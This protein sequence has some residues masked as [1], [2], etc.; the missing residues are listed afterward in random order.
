M[1]SGRTLL[2]LAV[3]A[4]SWWLWRS[5]EWQTIAARFS[6][7]PQQ[8]TSTIDNA[9]PADG[10][11]PA[12]QTVDGP[13]AEPVAGDIRTWVDA[14]GTRHFASAADAPENSVVHNT[15]P[16][17]I[18]K[19]YDQPLRENQARTEA[20]DNQQPTRSAPDATTAAYELMD[21][22]EQRLEAIRQ[23]NNR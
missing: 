22:L 9:L 17:T 21:N 16:A 18:L 1:I 6:S 5:G 20:A 12:T 14:Q 4:A 8:V 23:E 19:D 7:L 11:A 3:A 2:V 10:E 13:A 15:R